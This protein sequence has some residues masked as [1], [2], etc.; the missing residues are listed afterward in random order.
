MILFY[1]KQTDSSNTECNLF[2]VGGIN[3]E[4]HL[5]TD[6]VSGT[7]ITSRMSVSSNNFHVVT[8]TQED[9]GTSYTYYFVADSTVIEKVSVCGRG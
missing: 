7:L 5:S 9:N 1:F 6:R 8:A 3:T 4:I 2:P